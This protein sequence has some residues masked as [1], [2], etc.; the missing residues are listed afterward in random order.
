MQLPKMYRIRQK[1][2]NTRESDIRQSVLT[3]LRQLPW[4]QV[5]PGDRAAISAGSRGIANISKHPLP[6]FARHSR[7]RHLLSVTIQ[8]ILKLFR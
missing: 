5:Q 3:E 2:D 4:E 8:F 7:C 1:F 6:Y